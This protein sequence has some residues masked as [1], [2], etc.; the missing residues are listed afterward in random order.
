MAMKNLQALLAFLILIVS[1]IS[2]D[3]KT[4]SNVNYF[5][6]P[7]L[8]DDGNM[9]MEKVKIE[10]LN[11]LSSFHGEA[12]RI[13]IYPR[14]IDTGNYY[15][16]T[17]KS[18]KVSLSPIDNNTY[19]AKDNIQSLTV[20]S[21]YY[22]MEKMMNMLKS[23]G[24]KDLNIWP[25]DI[26]IEVNTTT[27]SLGASFVELGGFLLFYPYEDNKLPYDLNPYI[28]AHE[29][30]HAISHK[31]FKN[32]VSEKY[33]TNLSWNTLSFDCN[34]ENEKRKNC[35]LKKSII[36]TKSINILNSLNEGFADLWAWIYT[37]DDKA[38]S[39]SFTKYDN[40]REEKLTPQ[41]NFVMPSSD[42]I[43]A[44]F[45]AKGK[46]INP[47]KNI[48]LVGTYIKLLVQ[49][50]LEINANKKFAKR[51][52]NEDIKQYQQRRNRWMAHQFITSFNEI[53]S[54][55]I[56]EKFFERNL[57]MSELVKIIFD[58]LPIYNKDQCRDELSNFLMNYEVELNNACGNLR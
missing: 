39:R 58:S 1:V 56:L 5:E 17:G 4:A 34:S 12:A 45:E 46:L 55:K 26:G 53:M 54:V 9:K 19:I 2:C 49:K 16:L 38:M 47:K 32:K 15:K 40:Y 29:Y 36:N 23:S 20:I 50:I 27:A 3:S 7:I 35:S 52:L 18:P 44:L 28:M 11:D 14:I 51:S 57:N 25:I 31:V 21:I 30:F 8:Q 48:Y 10:T 24:L 37:Q 41:S 6:I 13:Y 43:S 22:H 42:H 33:K